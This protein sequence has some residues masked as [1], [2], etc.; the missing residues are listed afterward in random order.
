MNEASASV[1]LLLA[2]ALTAVWPTFHGLGWTGCEN[3]GI[4]INWDA[5]PVTF[6]C[7][8]DVP[9]WRKPNKLNKTKPVI[10]LMI[11]AHHRDRQKSPSVPGAAM[12]IFADRRDRRIKLPISGMSG[13]HSPSVPVSAIFYAHRCALPLKSTNQVGRFY[14]MTWRHQRGK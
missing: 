10:H 2:M 12:A 7:H 6:S 13:R 4:D 8:C 9:L 1:C 3:L 5:S 11:F 14:H